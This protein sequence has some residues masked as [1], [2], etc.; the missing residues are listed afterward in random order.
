[1]KTIF[2]EKYRYIFEKELV[3]E[4][5]KIGI[6]RTLEK[7]I[8]M[9]DVGDRLTQMPLVITGA[10]KVMNEDVE[11]NE[12]LLYYLEAGDSCTMTMTC[13]LGNQKSNIRAITES[14]TT[15]VMIPID[16]MEGWLVKYSTWRAF[17]FE[18]YNSRMAE[19][20]EAIDV[21][22]FHNMEE[23]L[24]K[25]LRDKAMVLH[26]P[27]LETTHYEIANDLNT[28]RV[29]ISRLMKKLILDQKI[30]T[31]RNQVSVIEFLPK[32]AEE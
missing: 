8:P 23:R 22:V 19:L 32:K 25:Y 9:I 30:Q 3:D 1:M 29:V 15:M 18:S 14:A 20:R 10:V 16:R 11:G 21:L 7:G 13:C 28:S 24:Y 2:L 5:L 27:T 17:V 12:Y 31:S 26:T 6:F 4:I